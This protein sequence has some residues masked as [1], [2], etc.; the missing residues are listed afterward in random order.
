MVG[1]AVKRSL[2]GIAFGAIITFIALTILMINEIET[3]V[4]TI[5]LYMLAGF[6]LGIYY[7]LASF[8][9][10]YER[11]SPLKKTIIHFSA[12]IIVYFAIALPIGWIEFTT[13][14]VV[15]SIAVFT[16]IYGIYWISF[17]LYFKKVESSLNRD[18][19]KRK[20]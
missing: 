14:A 11:W 15:L 12:S 20:L 1:K 3:E 13:R 4:A 7:G 16:I 6:V 9:F 17:A 5:W 10:E 2:Y 19:Q 8:I 18:L